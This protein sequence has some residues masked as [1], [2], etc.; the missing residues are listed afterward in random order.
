METNNINETENNEKN[1]GLFKPLV[2]IA[3]AIVA[4]AV[5]LVYNQNLKT[6][7][8]E[9]TGQVN[10]AEVPVEKCGI[11]IDNTAVD[12]GDKVSD[13]FEGRYVTYQGLTDITVAEDM[14]YQLQNP[15]K[16]DDIYMTFTITEEDKEI[17]KTD[18]IPAGKAYEADFTKLLGKG[19]HSISVL[20][21]PYI[22]TEDGRML[23]CPVNNAQTMVVNVNM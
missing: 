4:F 21:Q 1:S 17:V 9:V 8:T 7:T 11:T 10:A 3:V 12:I 6:V 14:T 20:M 16:E 23:A 18:F 5:T 15:N 2:V 19:V 22:Q 13:P